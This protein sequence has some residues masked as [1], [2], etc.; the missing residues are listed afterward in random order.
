[1]DVV[2]ISD[3]AYNVKMRALLNQ[4]VHPSHKIT[5]QCQFRKAVRSEPILPSHIAK[6]W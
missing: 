6:L 5:T 4:T 3:Q 1:M 2:L